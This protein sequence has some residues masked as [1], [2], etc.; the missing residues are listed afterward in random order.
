[1]NHR[2]AVC[3]LACLCMGA[4]VFAQFGPGKWNDDTRRE[5]RSTWIVRGRLEGNRQWLDDAIAKGGAYVDFDV[6]VETPIKGHTLGADGRIEKMGPTKVSVFVKDAA[7]AKLIA[8]ALGRDRILCVRRGRDGKNRFAIDVGTA[9]VPWNAKN[10]TTLSL[11]SG[12]A[13]DRA[14]KFLVIDGEMDLRVA[15]L[16]EEL[17]ESPERQRAALRDLAKLGEPAIASIVKRLDDD[18]KLAEASA[19]F[20]NRAADRFERSRTYAVKTVMQALCALLNHISGEHF[21]L[22]FTTLLTGEERAFVLRGWRLFASYLPEAPRRAVPES[23][24]IEIVGKLTHGLAGPGGEHTGTQIE[25]KGATL[26]LD[27]R[28]DPDLLR[29][30][31]GLT[32][33]MVRVTG[34]LEVKRGVEIPQRWIVTPKTLDLAK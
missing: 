26:E 29:S 5:A 13:K 24:T 6:E 10:F 15:G 34:S 16:I 31:R 9:I 20:R 21:A 1:M 19:T 14:A 3:L 22:D 32:G 23:I 33:R 17:I 27:L 8:K 2:V 25:A 28:G 12:L 11:L 30:A 7:S 4:S 18:R